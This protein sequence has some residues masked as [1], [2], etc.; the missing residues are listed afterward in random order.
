[1]VRAMAAYQ[2]LSLLL[3]DLG[4][5]ESV[6]NAE[7]PTTCITYL[8]VQFDSVMLT[9]S[10]ALEKVTEIKAEIGLWVRKT[11][12]TRSVPHSLLRKLFWI[13]SFPM[14]KSSCMHYHSWVNFPSTD[15]YR[16][17]T[18]PYLQRK[19]NDGHR[20]KNVNSYAIILLF[21]I[22]YDVNDNL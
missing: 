2:K 15:H 3:T 1:M 9:M 8:G 16:N 17:S 18:I 4:L 12:I 13:G 14:E 5:E 19:L 20:N 11:T 10:V 22:T 7:P 6:K 21:P